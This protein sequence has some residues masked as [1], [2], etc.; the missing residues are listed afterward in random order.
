MQTC[1]DFA[2]GCTV[3]AA[4]VLLFSGY[5]LGPCS[6]HDQGPADFVLGSS[7]YFVL[8]GK[9]LGWCLSTVARASERSGLGIVLYWSPGGVTRIGACGP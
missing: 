5:D 6:G 9:L 3:S 4:V 2:A 7:W 1:A 8:H